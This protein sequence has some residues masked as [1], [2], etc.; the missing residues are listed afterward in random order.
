MY[1][2]CLVNAGRWRSGLRLPLP[3]VRTKWN[4][5][6]EHWCPYVFPKFF[7][8]RSQD[9]HPSGTVTDLVQDIRFRVFVRDPSDITQNFS[10]GSAIG[11]NVLSRN[12]HSAG[13]GAF[14]KKT[15]VILLLQIHHLMHSPYLCWT[16]TWW[17][18]CRALQGMAGTC[19]REA[20]WV[21]WKW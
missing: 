1:S 7:G 9:W 10:H 11:S 20:F 5:R 14:S 12:A 19:P 13:F 18:S 4:N 15:Q 16:G 21:C 8:R 17:M 2:M 6:P 3:N